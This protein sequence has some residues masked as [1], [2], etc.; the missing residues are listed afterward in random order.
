MHDKIKTE[1]ESEYRDKSFITLLYEQVELNHLHQTASVAFLLNQYRSEN[2]ILYLRFLSEKLKYYIVS[3]KRRKMATND[4]EAFLSKISLNQDEH[5][6]MI[7]S[8]LNK[9]EDNISKSELDDNIATLIEKLQS[10]DVQESMIPEKAKNKAEQHGEERKIRYKRK[11][12]Q[13]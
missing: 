3:L 7:E 13:D 2:D 10:L 8:I 5:E 4:D 6:N 12:I 9:D 1:I 11:N